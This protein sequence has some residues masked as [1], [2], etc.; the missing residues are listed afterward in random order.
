MSIELT[1][2]QKAYFAE[3]AAQ[4]VAT[5]GD[6]ATEVLAADPIA[7]VTAAHQKRIEFIQEILEQRTDRSKMA[8]IALCTGVYTEASRRVLFERAIEH[9]GHIADRTWR[10]SIG[11]A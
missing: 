1:N 2:E 9:C 4:I 8:R 11:L 3:L 10:R 6:K 7:A 5:H